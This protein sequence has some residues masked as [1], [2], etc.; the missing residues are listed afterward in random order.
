MF[1]DADDMLE[2]YACEYMYNLAEEKNA[3]YISG[4]Y[5]MMDEFDKKR[6]KPAF[7]TEVYGDFEIKL[8]DLSR[9]F[10]VMNSTLWNKIYRREFLNKNN[11]KFDVNPPSEDDY[12][13]SL[14]YI[15]ANKGYYTSKVIC[16]YRLN[17]N[18]TSNKCDE[19]Y[20]VKQN[21]VYKTI[22]NSFKTN[23]KMGFYRYYYAK[24]SPY[25][26]CKL[27]DS[28][29]ISISEKESILKRLHWFFSLS[30]ELMI[31]S[32]NKNLIPLYQDIKNKEYDEALK[33]M[34]E[35]K[36]IRKKYS[37]FEKN[38]TCFPTLEQ[39]KEMSK[40]D[41]KFENNTIST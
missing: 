19:K 1:L 40:Y 20:F 15:K 38:R 12:F 7:D 11:I 3:D 4:N 9:S 34:E 6:E 14:A 5:V 25:L 30:D 36:Q 29:I 16:D 26:M 33:K 37:V 31:V 8:D 13:T 39:Y 28:D 18:S 21:D 27:I 2:D 10:M 35:I 32:A 41:D 24:K 17:P 23:E 22:Y